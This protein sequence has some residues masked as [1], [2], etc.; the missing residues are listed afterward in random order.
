M[1]ADL[2]TTIRA[3]RFVR[4][5]EQTALAASI[6]CDARSVARWGAGDLPG[7]RHLASLR[8]VLDLSIGE[9]DVLVLDH[10]TAGDARVRIEGPAVLDRRG[11]NH[12]DLLE[13]IL[14]LEL[15]ATGIARAPQRH[16]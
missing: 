15:R 16:G 5:M 11:W 12:H 1:P 7:A 3:R 2:A 8:A 9:M 13:R 6:G 14:D 10:L 4:G